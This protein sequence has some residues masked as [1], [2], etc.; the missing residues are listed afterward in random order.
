VVNGYAIGSP[1]GPV[2]GVGRTTTIDLW[3]S[4]C[5]RVLH[6]CRRG[7]FAAAAAMFSHQP[8]GRAVLRFVGCSHRLNDLLHTTGIWTNSKMDALVSL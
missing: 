3:A 4:A 7:H 6:S 2:A 1:A 8:H 5:S